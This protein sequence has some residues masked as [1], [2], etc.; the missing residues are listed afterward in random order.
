MHHSQQK[1]QNGLC[2]CLFRAC[3]FPRHLVC[4]DL[5]MNVSNLMV[6]CPKGQ[7]VE[8]CGVLGSDDVLLGAWSPMFLQNVTKHSSIDSVVSHSRRH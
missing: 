4:K 7:R 8:D 6:Q 1:V 5:K 2:Y 3:F